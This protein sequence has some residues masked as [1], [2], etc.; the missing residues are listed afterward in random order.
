MESVRKWAVEQDWTYEFKDDAFFS[1]A[2]EWARERCRGNPY[3]VTDICRLE[4][5]RQALAAGHA[6]AVWVDA[7][8]LVFAPERL[9]LLAGNG[10]GFARELFLQLNPDGSTTP[11]HGINNAMML[12]ERDEPV[13]Q[14]YLET[15]YSR[16]RSLPA[17]PVPRTALGPALLADLSRQHSLNRLEGIGLFSLA[18]M[19]DIAHGD[20]GLSREYLRHSPTV[21]AAANLCHFLRDATPSV[22]RPLF[23]GIYDA[24]VTRL[25]KS[26]ALASAPAAYGASS[27]PP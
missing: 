9:S 4:W 15:C 7:D 11:L 13:L 2:P 8:V 5:M 3:A 26:R 27:A 23:D 10:H 16:L 24:A 1:L 18:I 14:L 22:D 19:Q 25:L 21:P 6:R 20:G 17:G 12:F